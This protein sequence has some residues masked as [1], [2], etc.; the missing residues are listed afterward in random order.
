MWSADR[1]RPALH[2]GRAAGSRRSR[3]VPHRP[4]SLAAVS[5]IHRLRSSTPR[6]SRTA[7]G[8][9]TSRLK[10]G[11]QVS[12]KDPYTGRT[13][14]L[15]VAALAPRDYFVNNGV[16]YG[17]AGARTLFGYPLA[18][19]RLVH[20]PAAGHDADA[21]RRGRAGGV[22]GERRRSRLDP[23]DHGRGLH[24][25]PPDLPAL[26]GVPG[27]GSDRRH[28]RHR[29]RDGARR[30]RAAAPDRHPARTRLRLSLRGAELCDRVGLRRGRGNGDRCSC[31]RS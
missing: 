31:S 14:M 17:L 30:A 3:L 21:V 7:A 12:L 29:G 9:R 19:D 10:P 25:D 11:T 4:G 2:R 5:A 8:R 1:L 13:R 22:P 24:D 23:D 26:P 6:S 28:R 15:T 27:D 20:R 16:F 18:L